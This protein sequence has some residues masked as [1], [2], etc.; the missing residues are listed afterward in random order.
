MYRNKE[1]LIDQANALLATIRH[2]IELRKD[3][4]NTSGDNSDLA[5]QLTLLNDA[6]ER[7]IS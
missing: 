6:L 1:V 4:N 2:E 3:F 5:M 7:T